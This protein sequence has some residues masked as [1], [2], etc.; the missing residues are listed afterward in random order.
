MSVP[1]NPDHV[2]QLSN[3]QLAFKEYGMAL[4]RSVQPGANPAAFIHAQW[5]TTAAILEAGGIP[6]TV[7]RGEDPLDPEDAEA[8]AILADAMSALIAKASDIGNQP[9][10]TPEQKKWLAV[11]LHDITETLNHAEL[12]DAELEA[13]TEDDDEDMTLADAQPVQPGDPGPAAVAVPVA[14]AVPAPAVAVPAAPFV[15]IELSDSD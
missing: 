15:Y 9:G 6:V 10:N 1:V 2:L 7:T 4:R 12:K 11:K 5:N 14:V 3:V 13:V 8:R